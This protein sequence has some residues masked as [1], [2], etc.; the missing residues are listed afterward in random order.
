MLCSA[1]ELPSEKAT[2]DLYDDL[3]E[4]ETEPPAVAQP[5]MASSVKTPGKKSPTFAPSSR[6]RAPS[7][8]FIYR[9][10]GSESR[11]STVLPLLSVLCYLAL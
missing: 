10:G 11:V 9:G 6:T 4:V 3:Y 1:A 8:R 5:T 2:E 7:G